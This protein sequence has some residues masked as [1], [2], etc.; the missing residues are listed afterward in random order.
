[1]TA[2]TLAAGCELQAPL[3]R[4]IIDAIASAFAAGA[5]PAPSRNP[6]EKAFMKLQGLYSIPRRRARRERG[7]DQEGVS[8]ARTQYH[9]DVSKEKNAEERF[10]DIA[11]AYKTLKYPE[12]RAAYDQLGTNGR[13]RSSSTSGLG[14]AFRR[15][16]VFVED[17]TSAI[18]SSCRGTPPSRPAARPGRHGPIPG[19][20]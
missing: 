11:E 5:G 10:Q 14:A 8:Q 15:T 7:R 4:R 6:H 20:D 12:T 3:A 9:P 18:S 16:A 17:L 19:Q 2:S 13:S 1:M